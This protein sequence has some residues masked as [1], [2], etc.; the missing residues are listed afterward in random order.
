MLLIQ[1]LDVPQDGEGCRGRAEGS[2]K[3]MRI[4]YLVALRKWLLMVSK[5]K[6][7]DG[8][9]NIRDE[10]VPVLGFLQATECHFCAGDVLLRVLKVI[11]LENA[12]AQPNQHRYLLIPECPHSM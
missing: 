1:A 5:S 7:C 10:V 12:L 6:P 3:I 4:T 9:A 2:V 8:Y 11:E